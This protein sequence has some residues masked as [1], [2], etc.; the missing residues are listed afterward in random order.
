V[1]CTRPSYSLKTSGFFN[2]A[3]WQGQQAYLASTRDV[4][5]QI[6]SGLSS[7][8]SGKGRERFQPAI[9]APG[10]NLKGYFLAGFA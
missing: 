7:Q 4:V 1:V 5:Q 2:A 10:I 6:A 8:S 3:K 9:R